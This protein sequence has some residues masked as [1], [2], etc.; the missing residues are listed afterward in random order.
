MTERD[1]QEPI[2]R[3]ELLDYGCS[4]PESMMTSDELADQADRDNDE[5]WSE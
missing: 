5:R 3:D 1:L 4:L 2:T